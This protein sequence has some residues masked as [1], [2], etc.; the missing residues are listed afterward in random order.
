MA[1]EALAFDSPFDRFSGRQIRRLIAN[2]RARVCVSV[3]AR[4]AVLGW[5]VSL[6]RA[7]KRSRSGRV[8][9]VAV[10]PEHTG[11]GVGRAML[12]WMVDQLDQAGV[13]RV[14]LEVRTDNAGAIGLYHSEGFAIVR[15]LPGYYGDGDGL[16]MRRDLL[17]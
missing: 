8:Y 13:A 16:R 1:I 14:Y 5:C 10:S 7:H 3:D 12:R 11:R 6:I 4:D 15:R 9:S 2:P 17:D